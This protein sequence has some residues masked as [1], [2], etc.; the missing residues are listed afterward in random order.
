[1]CKKIKK[2]RKP[3]MPNIEGATANTKKRERIM[4]QNK[5]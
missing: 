1:M 5:N 2:D 4:N 3:F